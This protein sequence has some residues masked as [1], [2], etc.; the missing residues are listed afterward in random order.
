MVTKLILPQ[1]VKVTT[2]LRT[3]GRAE[4][5]N[6]QKFSISF[7]NVT[8]GVSKVKVNITIYLSFLTSTGW[9]T[10]G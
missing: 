10:R 5:R 4:F 1:H 9:K 7:L 2:L 6:G 8:L 3:A